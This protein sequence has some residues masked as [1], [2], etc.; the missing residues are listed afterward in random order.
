[1]LGSVQEGWGS[2]ELV[3][4]SK[5]QHCVFHNPTILLIY[6]HPKC[7]Q[8]CTKAFNENISNHII[9]KSPKLQTTPVSFNSKMINEL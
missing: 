6:V 2:R 1:M 9:C 3:I 5:P 7:I 4:S 8:M